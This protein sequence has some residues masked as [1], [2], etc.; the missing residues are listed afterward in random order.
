MFRVQA[1]HREDIDDV[2]RGRIRI[3]GTT[4]FRRH[5]T[6]DSGNIG[7]ARFQHHGSRRGAVLYQVSSFIIFFI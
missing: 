1:A 6:V 3:T 4:Q 7:Y 2:H 5:Q